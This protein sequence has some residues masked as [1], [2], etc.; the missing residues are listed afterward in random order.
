M[1]SKH[2]GQGV[3]GRGR[4]WE[5]KSLTRSKAQG[6]SSGLKTRNRKLPSKKGKIYKRDGKINKSRPHT[7]VAVPVLASLCF[8]QH[9]G[10]S[11]ESL[12]HFI[13]KSAPSAPARPPV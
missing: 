1:W 13:P 5:A 4:G 7:P 6:G 9:P 12:V 2:P 11:S 10:S 8:S 3:K